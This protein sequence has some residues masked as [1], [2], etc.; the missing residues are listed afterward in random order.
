MLLKTL[1]NELAA[2]GMKGIVPVKY[3]RGEAKGGK[4]RILEEQIHLTRRMEIQERKK[5]S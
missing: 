2:M 1:I 3:A 5:G 4:L